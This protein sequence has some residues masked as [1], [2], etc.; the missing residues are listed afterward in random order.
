ME[1]EFCWKQHVKKKLILHIGMGKTGTSALQDFFWANRALLEKNGLDYPKYGAVS[2]AHHLLSPHV[3]KHMA[4]N[5]RFKSFSEW[6]EKLKHTPLD[7][8]LLSSELIAW[9]SRDQVIEYCQ[10]LKE[11]FHLTVVIYVRRQDNIIMANYNQ[12][13]KAGWQKSAIENVGRIVCS[14]LII[15]KSST[16]GRRVWVI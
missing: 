16:R 1:S 5:W 12:L 15:E 8:I 6:A 7:T 10:C 11:H 14:N 2:Y 3:P 4:E 9:A 13:V